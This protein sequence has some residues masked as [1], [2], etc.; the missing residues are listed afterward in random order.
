MISEELRIFFTNFFNKR[1]ID[2]D[3]ELL[4]PETEIY[5]DLNI[6]DLD[7]DMF[8]GEFLKEFEID[9]ND[10]PRENY[11]GTGIPFVDDNVGFLKKIFGNK[12]WLPLEKEKRKPFTFKVLD[13]AIITKKL[14]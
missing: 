2:F 1:K 12:K 10:F 13:E 6:H 7:I 14:L 11:F 9:D 3:E 8:M 4:L 5:F